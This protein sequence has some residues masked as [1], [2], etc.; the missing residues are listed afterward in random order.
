MK[1]TAYIAICLLLFPSFSSV[2]GQGEN[3]AASRLLQS[4]KNGKPIGGWKIPQLQKKKPIKVISKSNI[5]NGE[6]S[7]EKENLQTS[8]K[9]ISKSNEPISNNSGTDLGG[10]SLVTQLQS[11]PPPI[12]KANLINEAK[13]EGSLPGKPTT[14]FHLKNLKEILHRRLVTV[15]VGSLVRDSHLVFGGQSAFL[16]TGQ[17]L[18]LRL[19]TWCKCLPLAE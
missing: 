6:T 5:T 1:I 2:H 7:E 10:N 17:M 13:R 9:D 15:P 3:S 19:K 8:S 14:L 16:S 18:I 4:I 12:P 11:T